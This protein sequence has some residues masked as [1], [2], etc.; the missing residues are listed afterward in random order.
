MFIFSVPVHVDASFLYIIASHGCVYCFRKRYCII[1]IKIR[2]TQESHIPPFSI[3][4]L[5]SE[6][7]FVCLQKL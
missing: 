5:N 1:T 6:F 4:H 7:E 2:L 3:Y